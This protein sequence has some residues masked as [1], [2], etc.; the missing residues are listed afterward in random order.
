MPG[1]RKLIFDASK[2][3]GA[4]Y[5]SNADVLVMDQAIDAFLAQAVTSGQITVSMAPPAAPVAVSKFLLGEASKRKLNLVHPKLRACVELAITL[6][7][8]DFTVLEGRRSLADQ[9]EAVATGHSRTMKSKH[10][11]QLDGTVHAV[12]LGAW[13]NNALSWNEKFYAAIAYA[14]DQAATRLGCADHIRWGAAWDRVLSDYGG[15]AA[16]Y[17]AEAQAYAKRHA[18]SDLIDMPHFEWVA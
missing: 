3:L 14:M 16:A 9:K 5:K 17:L 15:S 18:G 4:V 1:D 13:V 7:L 11:L 8:C 10:L 2:K 6:S 12:D